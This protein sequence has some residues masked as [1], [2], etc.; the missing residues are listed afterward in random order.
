[1]LRQ[2][3]TQQGFWLGRLLLTM[4]EIAGMKNSYVAP[5]DG[6]RHSLHNLKGVLG[7]STRAAAASSTNQYT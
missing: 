7:Y 5:S 1:M 6:T 4:D 3:L 2:D